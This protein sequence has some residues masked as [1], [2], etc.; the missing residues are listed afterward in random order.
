MWMKIYLS[1]I[2]LKKM[3]DKNLSYSNEICFLSNDD[4]NYMV[5]PN[6]QQKKPKQK[7]DDPFTIF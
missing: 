1:T 5:Q 7:S 4:F 3:L 2:F 6:L